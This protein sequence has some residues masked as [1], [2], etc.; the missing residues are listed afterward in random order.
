MPITTFKLPSTDLDAELNRKTLDTLDK[1]WMRYA[2]NEITEHQLAAAMQTLYSMVF[3]LV[4]D[5]QLADVVDAYEP[6][7]TIS[8]PCY[9]VRMR[10]LNNL[11]FVSWRAGDEYIEVHDP[12]ELDEPKKQLGLDSDFAKAGKA[13]TMHELFQQVVEAYQRG[14][15]TI[16]EGDSY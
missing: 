11:R 14:G 8:K 10:A 3:G 7:L 5:N 15:Y 12:D 9:F 6:V 2:N 13:E 1:L 4:S 16:Q